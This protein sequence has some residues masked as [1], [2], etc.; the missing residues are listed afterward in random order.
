LNEV[1]FAAL[2]IEGVA[3]RAQTGKA[4][5][6]RRWPSKEGLLREAF[7]RCIPTPQEWAMGTL[8]ASASVRDVLLSVMAA[9]ARAVDSERSGAAHC[10]ASEAVRDPELARLLDREVLRPRLNELVALL[11]TGIDRGQVAAQA[12]VEMVAELAQSFVLTRTLLRNMTVDVDAVREFVDTVAMP[13]LRATAGAP[14]D[15]PGGAVPIAGELA[16]E[17]A[18]DSQKRPENSNRDTCESVVV[19]SA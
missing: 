4:S 2:T 9:T 3:A 10:F 6:Y 1:G 12:P 5:I 8:P 14:D 18:D 11:R 16:D 15:A 17:S 13:L 7:A 19:P